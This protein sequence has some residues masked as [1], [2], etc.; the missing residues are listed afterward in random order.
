MWELL[1]LT[2]ACFVAM[3]MS[4]GLVELHAKAVI[5]RKGAG[6]LMGDSWYL[7]LLVEASSTLAVVA[8]VGASSPLLH[9]QGQRSSHD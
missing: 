2:A 9:L 1:N 6:I 5:A 4:R 3:M 8:L 7:M